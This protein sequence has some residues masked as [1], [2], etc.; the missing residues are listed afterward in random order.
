MTRFLFNRTRVGRDSIPEMDDS[1][2][3][4]EMAHLQTDGEKFFAHLGEESDVLLE[5]GINQDEFFDDTFERRAH[6]IQRT[7]PASSAVSVISAKQGPWSGN[8]NLGIERHFSPD[9]NNLQTILKMPEWGFPEV[10][11][12]CLGLNDF[13]FIPNPNPIG[14]EVTALIEFGIG[15]AMQEVEVD[16]LNGT[17]IS[18]PMNAVNIVARYTFL[19]DQDFSTSAPDD[20]RLRA[21][22]C[23]GR[24]HFA[25]P[26]R[27]ISIGE[28]VT[29]INIPK[30]AKNVFVAPR[31]ELPGLTAYGFYSSG[32][33]VELSAIANQSALTCMQAQTSQF[34]SYLDTGLELVGSPQK[35]PVPPTARFLNFK[36]A[37][38]V[39]EANDGAAFA[40]FEIGL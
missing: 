12:I 13:S 1:D 20:L 26:T 35:I 4:R 36:N 22:I 37:S 38:N 16:W 8:N 6:E 5:P 39:S 17:A 27:T 3:R 2:V 9:V 18:L 31:I 21:T 19:E 7:P 40:Q 29:S 15:G 32:K 23:R 33:L 11:T 30:F 10:W 25:R 34:V 24:S 14:F 28:G